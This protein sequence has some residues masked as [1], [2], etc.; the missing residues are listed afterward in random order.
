MD[1]Q[2]HLAAS[3]P[4]RRRPLT[5]VRY[6]CATASS[7]LPLAEVVVAGVRSFCA[8][9]FAALPAG[10]VRRASTLFSG[11]GACALRG[12]VGSSA[13]LRGDAS[14][15]DGCFKASAVG[16]AA[17]GLVGGSSAAF[18]GGAAAGSASCE[19]AGGAGGGPCDV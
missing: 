8:T 17:D 2:S 7:S 1:L 12:A 19:A 16:F 3:A 9:S 14:F 6:R 13:F 11:R 10:T 18:F 5:P 15:G 4:S